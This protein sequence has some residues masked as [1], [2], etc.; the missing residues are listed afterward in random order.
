M[1]D[2]ELHDPLFAKDMLDSLRSSCELFTVSIASKNVLRI[3]KLATQF[4]PFP[5]IASCS[6]DSA[7]GAAASSNASKNCPY[8]TSAIIDVFILWFE[9]KTVLAV[10][11][12]ECWLTCNFNITSTGIFERALS[13]QKRI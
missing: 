9:C 1:E 7:R 8:A 10:I 2:K 6:F 4:F 5:E 13:G 11:D 12:G 3:S